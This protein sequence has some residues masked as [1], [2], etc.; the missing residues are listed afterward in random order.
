MVLQNCLKSRVACISCCLSISVCQ[1]CMKAAFPAHERLINHIQ[2][3]PCF[4]ETNDSVIN[5]LINLDHRGESF[6]WDFLPWG[7]FSCSLSCFIRVIW[8][9]VVLY[10]VY[11]EW[12]CSDLVSGPL[13]DLICFCHL[14]F[15][16]LFFFFSLLVL[17]GSFPLSSSSPP[18]LFII[19]LCCRPVWFRSTFSQCHQ[20]WLSS[21]WRYWTV[22]TVF[23][24]NAAGLTFI[25]WY[26][27]WIYFWYTAT[28][29]IKSIMLIF[30]YQMLIFNVFGVFSFFKWQGLQ[31]THHLCCGEQSCPRK[32]K[33]VC[34][35]RVHLKLI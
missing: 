11:S 26:N 28:I 34:Q 23:H 24:C 13:S 9:A 20:D 17:F 27:T 25:H 5:A 16:F 30:I 12:W 35:A 31:V 19:F 8:R 15:H 3:P 4:V 10:P 21:Y 18:T 32:S 14:S 7:S 2:Y 29:T 6:L 33:V 1:N 22:L